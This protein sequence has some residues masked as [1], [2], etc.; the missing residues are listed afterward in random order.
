MKV[1]SDTT[2]AEKRPSNVQQM[3]SKSVEIGAE[4]RTEPILRCVRPETDYER[5]TDVEI[6]KIH[7]GQVF[8]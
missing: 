5:N 7:A 6:H 4:F 8:Y 2:G 1:D 3:C